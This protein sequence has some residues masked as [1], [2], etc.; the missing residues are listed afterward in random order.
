MDE[1]HD[2]QEPK[3][4]IAGLYN[5]VASLFGQVGPDF[6]SYA[7]RHLVERM[8]IAEGAKVLDVAVGRGA[9]LFPAAEKVGLRGQA[10]GIDLAEKPKIW[11]RRRKRRLSVGVSRMRLCCRWMP[12]I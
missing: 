1:T 3:T 4:N 9:N 6:F 7:G 10:I 5:R 12:N 8:D 11:F 2:K